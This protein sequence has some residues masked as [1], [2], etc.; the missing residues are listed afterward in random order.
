MENLKFADIELILNEEIK[1]ISSMKTEGYVKGV[2]Y[3]KNQRELIFIYNFLKINE[4]PFYIIG[5]GTNVLFS[6]ENNKI[7][8]ISLQKMIKK[9]KKYKNFVF[10]DS[11]VTLA[12]AFQYCY[13]NDRSC[14]ENLSTI[15]G[16]I[17]GA[18]KVNAGCFGANIFDNL[19]SIKILKNGKIKTLTKDKIIYGYRSTNIDDLILSAKFETTPKNKCELIKIASECI[20]KRNEKQPKGYSLGCIFKNPPGFS[21]GFLIEECG[22]KG[23]NKNDAYI[24]EKHA[25]FIINKGKANFD[26]V[27]YLINL[28]KESVKKNFNIDLE[29]EIK[30]YPNET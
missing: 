23:E 2:F 30:I 10:V 28:A 24:S 1:K 22:L 13:K 3:P 26:D 9:I 7:L 18:I 8:I 12:E 27:M 20:F 5:K 4:I 16:S 25:N 11:S 29:L 21:A 6:S 14:F 19:V 17:G 15:P